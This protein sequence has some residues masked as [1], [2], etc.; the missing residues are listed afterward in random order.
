MVGAKYIREIKPGEII[1]IDKN[2]FYSIMGRIPKPALC[3]FEYIYFSRPDSF[4]EDQLIIKVRERLGIQLAKE[5]PAIADIVVGVPE[6]SVP[7]AIGYSKQS[8]IPYNEGIIKNRYV[9]RTFIQPTQTLRELGVS[10]KF[11]PIFEHL[12]GKKIVLIDDSIVRGNTTKNLIKILRNAG[13]IEIHMRVSSP[14][15]RFP[16]FMGIDMATTDQMIAF[17]RKEEE[18]CKLINADSLKYLSPEGLI[19]VI[20]EGIK[21][22]N[23]TGYCNACFTGQYPLEIDDW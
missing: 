4:L 17:N 6:S 8:G 19:Q 18:I 23:H 10:M 13:V 9:H 1:K 22:E 3:V 20:K 7:A 15:I 5:A 2:G 11:T 14:P 21:K 16:C 12:K